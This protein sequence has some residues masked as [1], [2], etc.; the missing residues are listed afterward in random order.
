VQDRVRP[1]A[2]GAGGYECSALD[3]SSV[4][5]AFAVAATGRLLAVNKRFASLIGARS[6]KDL[7]G[8][9]LGD[10]MVHR[11]DWSAWQRAQVGRGRTGVV[12]TLRGA[13]GQPVLLKGDLLPPR[14]DD[15]GSAPTEPYLCGTFIDV[16]EEHN[17]RQAV[18]R[19]ARMEALGSLT[20]GIAH[21]FNNLLTVLVGN[22]YLVGEELRS[23]PAV[24]EKVKSARDAAKRG[25]D[26]IRQ[27]LAFARREAIETGAVDPAKVIEGLVPLL[28]HALG[29]RIAL[30]TKLTAGIG[31]VACSAGQ[32]ES[33]IVNLSVNARDAITLKDGSRGNGRVLISVETVN[34]TAEAKTRAEVGPGAYF[35]IAVSDDGA[36]I[37]KA[38][39]GR[40]FD[41]FFSTKREHGG[42]GLGLSMVRWFVE[43]ANGGVYVDSAVGKGTRVSLLLPR[44]E[45]HADTTCK[46]MP[47]SQLPTGT[48]RVLVFSRDEALRST[49]QQILEVLGYSVEL[50][51]DPHDM[52]SELRSSAIDVLVVDA[53]AQPPAARQELLRKARAEKPSLKLV[54]AADALDAKRAAEAGGAVVLSKP[55]SL[56]DLAGAVRRALAG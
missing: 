53:A 51:A 32:L 10:L 6:R 49:I 2:A 52:L 23:Q 11:V 39:L 24:F 4:V 14:A 42:T 16:S 33:V 12:L 50:S 3:E 37:P 18:Q 40:I 38:V 43:Q 36:G 5:A 56:A 55:F 7:I 35:R 9:S 44:I 28:R 27:L 41:P 46:T 19:G 17:L 29:S 30:E 26:L 34:V 47:L 54:I 13:D 15:G 31:S 22:L 21:D 45:T 20:S 8:T 1:L 48:E 25:A